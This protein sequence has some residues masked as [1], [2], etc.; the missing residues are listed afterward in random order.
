MLLVERVEDAISKE[1]AQTI[2]MRT[3]KESIEKKGLDP[4]PKEEH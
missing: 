3:A 4:N 1:R 2:Q